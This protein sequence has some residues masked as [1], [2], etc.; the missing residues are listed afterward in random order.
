MHIVG[1]Q[2]DLVW[3]DA[4][5][6]RDLFRAKVEA[7]AARA[8]GGLIVLPEMW[9][10]G[11]S[12]HADR[13]AEAE[14]GASE[15][16]LVEMALATGAA[17]AGS[18][19]QMRDGW[20]RPRNVFLLANPQGGIHRY[21]K[22]HP[23]VFGGESRHYEA[24]D[25]LTSVRVAGVRVT[26]LICYDLRFAEV[27]TARASETDLFV[28]VANW[29]ATRA[30]HW[31]ALLVSRAIETQAYVLGVNRIGTGGGLVYEGD[32]LL[33]SPLGEILSSL[34][35]GEAGVV[36]GEV[37]PAVVSEV[38]LSLPFLRDRRPDVYRNL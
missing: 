12:M 27:F 36:E 31:K 3:E 16:F 34:P 2:S 35:P 24:G 10:S 23:F 18:V 38:R 22:I 25:V 29:P 15:S 1:L 33:V 4:V 11:F 37:D 13:I 7:V 30:H 21:A 14:G 6:N 5:A 9:P 19:A 32:S 26:P 28:V 8:V 17:I 20:Q